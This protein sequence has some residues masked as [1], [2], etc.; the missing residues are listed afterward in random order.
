[1]VYAVVL[2]ALATLGNGAQILFVLCWPKEPGQVGLA[3][4]GWL[5]AVHNPKLSSG[6]RLLNNHVRLQHYNSLTP[7]SLTKPNFLFDNPP[8]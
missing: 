6:P 5:I 4:W 3:N 1:M 2:L 8:V 7:H